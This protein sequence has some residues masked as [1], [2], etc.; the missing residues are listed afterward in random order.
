MTIDPQLIDVVLDEPSGYP[1]D[2][3][4]E[5]T[6]DALFQAAGDTAREFPRHLWIEPSDWWRP[7]T[8]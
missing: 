3:A 4:A 1:D 6:R 2:L 7:G 8:T 5:D